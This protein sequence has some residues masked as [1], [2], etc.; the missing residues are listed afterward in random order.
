MRQI[1]SISREIGQNAASDLPP[2]KVRGRGSAR[3][4]LTHQAKTSGKKQN[5][6]T[7]VQSAVKSTNAIFA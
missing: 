2:P 1:I 7:G 3:R 6:Q 5:R 4:N